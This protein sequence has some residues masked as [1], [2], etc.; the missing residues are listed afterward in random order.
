[1]PDLVVSR[2]RKSGSCGIIFVTIAICLVVASG[3][4][5]YLGSPFQLPPRISIPWNG[6]NWPERTLGTF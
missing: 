2:A 4:L 1:M 3:I 6:T 5:L